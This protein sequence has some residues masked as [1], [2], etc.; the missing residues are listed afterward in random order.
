M[1]E[2][3]PKNNVVEGKPDLSEI[4]MDLMAYAAKAWEYGS[5]VKYSRNSWRKGFPM[6]ENVRAI[7]SHLSDFWEK[8]EDYDQDA[9]IKGVAVHH[10]GCIIFNACCLLDAF[11]NHP[12]LDDRFKKPE[13]RV[14]LEE[15]VAF[16]KSSSIFHADSTIDGSKIEMVGPSLGISWR[17]CL[18][19]DTEFFK[20][21]SQTIRGTNEDK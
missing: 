15:Q 2:R 4:P 3:A 8:G 6:H 16:L 20:S 21:S 11:V 18:P 1:E 17:D 9:A 14:L 19:K 12:E 7:R 10:L 13:V 5:K